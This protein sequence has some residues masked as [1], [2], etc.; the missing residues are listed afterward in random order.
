MVDTARGEL[1]NKGLPSAATAVRTSRS[2]MLNKIATN[3]P[4]ETSV[5]GHETRGLAWRESLW[6]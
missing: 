5:K 6:P 2:M 3:V 1:A 4:F